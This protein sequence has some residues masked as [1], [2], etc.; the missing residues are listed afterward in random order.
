MAREALPHHTHP[1]NHDINILLIRSAVGLAHV[2]PATIPKVRM[3][4]SDYN[5]LPPMSSMVG[6]AY[7]D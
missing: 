3:H 4:V 5:A 1:R 6:L 7:S 2:R